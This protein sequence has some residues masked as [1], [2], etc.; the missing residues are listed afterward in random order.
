M[1]AYVIVPIEHNIK[2]AITAAVKAVEYK[3][4][5]VE[6]DE[7]VD[8]LLTDIFRVLFP[9][10]PS[11]VSVER[12]TVP[13]VAA[14]SE[15]APAPAPAAAAPEKKKRAPAKPKAKKEAE[16]E[17]KKEE[18]EPE[19]VVAGAGA[20]AAGASAAVGP[21]KPA[22]KKRGPKPK[23]VNQ[24]KLDAEQK[25]MLKKVG[26]DPKAFLEHVNALTPDE[27][28]AATLEEHA[29]KFG[30]PPSGPHKTADHVKATF[31]V[32]EFP[33]GSGTEYHV[34]PKTK[35]VYKMSDSDEVKSDDYVGDVGMLQFADMELA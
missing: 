11:L 4:Y 16:P 5:H 27:F 22:P 34:D 8:N 10:N 13:I 17:K 31:L 9:H 19:P 35:K 15:P 7:V 26:V 12:V 29:V 2:Q 32:V 33:E 23:V 25:K 1:S 20:A 14:E 21:E 18:A 30:N 28:A 3:K 6:A 24:A